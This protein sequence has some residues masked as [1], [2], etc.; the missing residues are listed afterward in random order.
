ME[1]T[2]VLAPVNPVTARGPR[3]RP[4]PLCL[5]PPSAKPG[6]ETEFGGV[7]ALDGIGF[8]VEDFE[9]RDRAEDFL[10][11]DAGA[12]VPGLEQGWPAE[13]SGGQG[14]IGHGTAAHDRLGVGEGRLDQAVDAGDVG[15]ADE[16]SHI[17]FRVHPVADADA[18]GQ[19]RQARAD[20]TGHSALHQDPLSRSA[21]SNTIIG[22]LPP[23]S[24]FIRL[25][26]A[27][28]AAAARRPAV[29]LPV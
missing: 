3:R 23:S 15:L 11:D 6:G 10:L 17:R 5:Q 9:G 18:F 21:S 26:V 2:T 22:V 7:G 14:A 12:D 25:R 8:G 28:P 16:R 20:F 27:A 29:V 13:R 19:A 24:R 1:W 4:V